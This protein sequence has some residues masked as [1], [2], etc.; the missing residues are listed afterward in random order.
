MQLYI[1][2]YKYTDLKSDLNNGHEKY[3]L[4]AHTKDSSINIISG[5]VG[6]KLIPLLVQGGGFNTYNM[7]G[8]DEQRFTHSN[9]G[10]GGLPC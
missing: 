9:Y 7:K 6:R 3:T 5:W 4:S 2:L 8:R 10:R 1:L